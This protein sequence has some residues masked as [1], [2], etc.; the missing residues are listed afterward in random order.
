MIFSVLMSGASFVAANASGAIA[1]VTARPSCPPLPSLFFLLLFHE[2]TQTLAP[3]AHFHA[4][5]PPPPP[6]RADITIITVIF[7]RRRALV[8]GHVGVG[9]QAARWKM[10]IT[11]VEKRGILEHPRKDKEQLA[12]M[13]TWPRTERRPSFDSASV[14]VSFC[15]GCHVQRFHRDADVL[16]PTPT[17]R[18]PGN[19][20]TTTAPNPPPRFTG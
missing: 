9:S 15:S 4:I 20:S 16:D 3:T 18:R 17:F 12:Q 8:C 1:N 7:S 11:T 5:T 13:L 19:R 10:V 6:P 2:H 14:S